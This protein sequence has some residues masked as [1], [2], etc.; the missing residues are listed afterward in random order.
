VN[1][2]LRLDQ[3][4]I[5]SFSN[6]FELISLAWQFALVFSS[7]A[8]V[9]LDTSNQDRHEDCDLL[10][11]KFLSGHS[12]LI[13]TDLQCVCAW[14]AAA[15]QF[16][17]TNISQGSVTTPFRCGRICNDHFIANFLPN[18]IVKEF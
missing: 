5:T 15:V 14:S 2:F 17:E 8:G 1:S 6:C 10:N 18:V 12:C 7:L 9:S 3:I 16:L 11:N 13:V 4:K